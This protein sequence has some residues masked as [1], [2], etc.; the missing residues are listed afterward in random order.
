VDSLL[1]N[2]SRAREKLGWEPR[3]R[4]AELVAE[5]VRED[6]KEAEREQFAKQHGFATVPGRE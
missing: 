1:G 5:M 2:A 3:I 4:F 6:L